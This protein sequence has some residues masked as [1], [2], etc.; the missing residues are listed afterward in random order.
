MNGYQSVSRIIS[1]AGY[2]KYF[3]DAD[4]NGVCDNY[5]ARR[6]RCFGGCHNR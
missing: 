1:E 3:A 5:R 6:R 2:G 4:Y